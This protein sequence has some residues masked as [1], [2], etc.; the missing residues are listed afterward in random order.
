MRL[1]ECDWQ[2]SMTGAGALR[3]ARL[4]D[5][6]A[7]ELSNTLNRCGR[8]CSSV[9][10]NAPFMELERVALGLVLATTAML[11]IRDDK[12]KTEKP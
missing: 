2:W 1:F 3:G 5:C 9:V 6:V 12:T 8:A 11:M 4:G 10:A 7:N